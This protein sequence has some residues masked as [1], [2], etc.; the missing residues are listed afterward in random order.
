MSGRNAQIQAG[1]G[2]V[3][4][5]VPELEYK[6]TLNKARAMIRAIETAEEGLA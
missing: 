4:D 3:L 5:S 2:I 1:A 6:E